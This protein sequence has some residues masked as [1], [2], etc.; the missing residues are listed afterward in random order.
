MTVQIEI[1][2]VTP[3]GPLDIF[4]SP[5]VEVLCRNNTTHPLEIDHGSTRVFLEVR[6][7]S[8][9]ER[10]LTIDGDLRSKFL[11]APGLA[12]PLDPVT[13]PAGSEARI[14][15]DL[16]QFYYPFMAG[17]YRMVPC[18]FS[19]E[20][21][22]IR[23]KAVPISVCTRTLLQ[24]REWYENPVFGAEYLLCQDRDG[25]QART[26]LRWLG[27]NRP[28]ASFFIQTIPSPEEGLLPFPSIAGFYGLESFKPGFVKVIIWQSPT[29]ETHIRKFI[30]G[31]MAGDERTCT[32]PKS[33]RLLPYSFRLADDTVF[34]FALEGENS[35]K[36]TKLVKGYRID[37]AGDISACLECALDAKAGLF[38]L[39]G[40]PD[41]IQLVA[42]GPPLAH[43]I[44][45]HSGA[46]AQKTEIGTFQGTPLHL[47]VDLPA[48]SIRAIYLDP[49]DRNTLTLVES[50]FP[51]M[52]NQ[53][54]RPAIGSAR[55]A[56]PNGDDFCEFDFLFDSVS[57]LNILYSTKKK[58]LVF[59]NS[60]LGITRLAHGETAYFPK[61]LQ[62]AALGEQGSTLPF[63]GFFSGKRGYRFYEAR[64][65]RP[66]SYVR[67]MR[68]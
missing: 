50:P 4:I 29:G 38:A 40:G 45:S 21:G 55:L 60:R 1:S 53:N 9:E 30:Q 26:T 52:K 14:P 11:F 12:K 42:S 33:G 8:G 37:P 44:F 58:H 20:L 67:N 56:L 47:S 48:D 7:E 39:G 16:A 63:V 64:G 3:G 59:Y 24:I 46:L 31:N 6:S 54:F 32:L 66:W 34:L 23:G 43:F 13:I 15:F 41:T 36:K 35:R 68:I 51:S 5:T 19:E 17:N 65:L 2:K 22:A 28:L 27:M 62:G 57:R 49:K 61:L 25:E 18:L 10:L